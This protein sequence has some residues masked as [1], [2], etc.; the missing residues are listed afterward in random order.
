MA[1]TDDKAYATEQRLNAL[2]NW[3]A[4]FPLV[5]YSP[6]VLTTE[7]PIASFGPIPAHDAEPN[8]GGQPGGYRVRV[9]GLASAPNGQTITINAYVNGDNGADGALV[10]SSGARVTQN[11]FVNR[12]WWLELC[13]YLTTT[14]SSGKLD[15]AGTYADALQSV[16]NPAAPLLNTP[17]IPIGVTGASVE[18]NTGAAMYVTVTAVFQ[19][20]N[21]A[22]GIQA[23]AGSMERIGRW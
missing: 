23:T 15:V 6:S 9:R 19:N 3:T 12:D 17:V 22:N 2:I 21:A 13:F 16:S 5:T 10:A 11:S 18:V 7:V 20:S 8:T 4:S 14:G 1:S